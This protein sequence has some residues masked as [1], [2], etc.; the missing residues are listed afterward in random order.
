M[1]RPTM[2]SDEQ[3]REDLKELVE[4]LRRC[5]ESLSP[6]ARALL[7]R[8]LLEFWLRTR[9][10]GS[11]VVDVYGEDL[12][13]QDLRAWADDNGFETTDEEDDDSTGSTSTGV[14]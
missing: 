11:L 8:M 1:P 14:G 9:Y 10:Q 6:G 13:L 4:T 5:S 3:T 2:T 12:A 7:C